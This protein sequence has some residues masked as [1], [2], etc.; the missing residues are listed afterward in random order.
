VKLPMGK[1]VQVGQFAAMMRLVGLVPSEVGLLTKSIAEERQVKMLKL[2]KT[3]L[4]QAPAD[5][6]FE[7]ILDP[8]HL[9]EIWPSMVEVSDVKALPNGGFTF[10]WVYKM[11][12]VR[13]SGESECI[14]F[15][16]ATL[17]SYKNTVIESVITWKLQPENDQ[18]RVFFTSEYTLP[19]ALLGKLAEPVVTKLNEHDA[20]ALLANLRVRIETPIPAGATR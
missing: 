8:K 2:E 12:G 1:Y 18:T 6:V 19:G 11:A 4:I 7:Y 3:L 5:K 9:P 20:D 10:K 15:K 14:E 16:P 17:L 13:F